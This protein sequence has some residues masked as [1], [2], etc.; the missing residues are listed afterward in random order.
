M[1]RRQGLEPRTRGLRV[2]NFNVWMSHSMLHHADVSGFEATPV[3][4]VLPCDAWV[5]NA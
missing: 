5:W 3:R 4:T 1:V 2:R